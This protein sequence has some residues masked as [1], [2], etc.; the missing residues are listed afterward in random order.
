MMEGIYKRPV[1]ALFTSLADKRIGALRL[2]C[3]DFFTNVIALDLRQSLPETDTPSRRGKAKPSTLRFDPPGAAPLFGCV[4]LGASTETKEMTMKKTLKNIRNQLRSICQSMKVKV[5]V[6]LSIPPF[7]KIE[8][9]A[10]RT[11]TPPDKKKGE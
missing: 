11:V 6:I 7:L 5:S 4:A 9:A 3:S 8:V 1:Y 2:F 10:E